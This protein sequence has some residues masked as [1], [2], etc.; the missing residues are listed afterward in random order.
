MR[1]Q[2]FCSR[3]QRAFAGARTHDRQ[4]STD[5]ESDALPTAPRHP[6]VADVDTCE[7]LPSLIKM[8]LQWNYVK[9]LHSRF[10]SSLIK[11]SNQCAHDAGLYLHVPTLFISCI[12]SK[13]MNEKRNNLKLLE[14]P[15]LYP[16]AHIFLVKALELSSQKII[17]ETSK[18]IIL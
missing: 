11:L 3:K 9:Y 12:Y 14:R 2:F 13:S 17:T 5:Y 8:E 1:V 16:S 4:A 10:D 7:S 18:M 15:F 6:I